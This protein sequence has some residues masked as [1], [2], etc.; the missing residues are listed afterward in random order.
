MGGWEDGKLRGWEG[1][2]FD[3]LNW[4]YWLHWFIKRVVRQKEL[5]HM[6]NITVLIFTF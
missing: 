2:R 1:K 3:L 6:L 4:L 5:S